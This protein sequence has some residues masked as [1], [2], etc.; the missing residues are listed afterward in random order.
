MILV[1]TLIAPKLRNIDIT[2]F[3]MTRRRNES[4]APFFMFQYLL[5]VL[6]G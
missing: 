5:K 1:I 4:A 6:R 3:F 2:L